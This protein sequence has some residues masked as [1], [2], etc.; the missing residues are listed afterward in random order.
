MAD[1]SL[2]NRTEFNIW[3]SNMSVIRWHLASQL[4]NTLSIV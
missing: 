1:Q 3:E 4:F 2:S